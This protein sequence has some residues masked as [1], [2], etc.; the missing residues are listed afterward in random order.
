M[1]F[2]YFQIVCGGDAEMG[3]GRE[4]QLADSF[5]YHRLQPLFPSHIS[6]FE[7]SKNTTT[8]LKIAAVTNQ[9]TNG[10]L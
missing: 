8:L 6:V 9:F 2:I 1:H 10:V 4:P 7:Q 3:Q 5:L